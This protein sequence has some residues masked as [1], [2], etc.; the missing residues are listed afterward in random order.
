MRAW[1]GRDSRTLKALTSRKFR[2]VVGSRPCV[3]LDAPSWLDAATSH[4]LCTSYR[5]GDIYARDLGSLAV[6]ATQI[7]L[8]AS[9]NGED[10]SGQVWATDLWRKSKV[11]R[12]WL[13]VE[14][15]LS[16]PETNPDIPAAIRSLQLWR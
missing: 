12:K 3:I 1:I 11:R 8:E 2:M 15:V 9:I 13:M 7:D 4:F 14:R 5:F 10:W 16:R 6:F